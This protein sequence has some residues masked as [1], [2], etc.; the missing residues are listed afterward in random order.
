M[1]RST[2][3]FVFLKELII[4]FLHT[5]MFPTCCFRQKTF[6]NLLVVVFFVVVVVAVFFLAVEKR[7]MNGVPAIKKYKIS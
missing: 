1:N 3:T 4:S 2:K 7:Q 5:C 6:S